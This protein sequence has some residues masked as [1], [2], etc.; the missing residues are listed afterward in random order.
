MY[1]WIIFFNVLILI[2]TYFL[3]RLIT[4]PTDELDTTSEIRFFCLIGVNVIISTSSIISIIVEGVYQGIKLAFAS[5][6]TITI[7]ISIC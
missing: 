3:I 1:K 5:C 6:L 7:A 2:S 4:L